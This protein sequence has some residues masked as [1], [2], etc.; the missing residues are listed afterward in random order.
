MIKILPKVIDLVD[1]SE[2]V[3]NVA[4]LTWGPARVHIAPPSGMFKEDSV[5]LLVKKR[6]EDLPFRDILSPEYSL[7]T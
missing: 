6:S 3:V 7:G 5:A 1:I 4:N 2:S